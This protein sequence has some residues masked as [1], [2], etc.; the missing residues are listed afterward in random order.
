MSFIKPRLLYSTE[1]KTRMFYDDYFTMYLGASE[2]IKNILADDLISQSE[3]KYLESLYSYNEEL[4]KEC[5]SI[6]GT[7]YEGFDF[8]KQKELEKNVAAYVFRTNLLSTTSVMSSGPSDNMATE[9]ISKFSDST[10]KT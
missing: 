2:V 9:I 3:K 8:D 1:L 10:F 4:I 6:I 7:A 5:K